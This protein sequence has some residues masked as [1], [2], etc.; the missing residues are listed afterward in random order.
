MLFFNKKLSICLLIIWFVI[1][2]AISPFVHAHIGKDNPAS[3]GSGLH[4]HEI[5]VFAFEKSQHH[6]N[7]NDYAFDTH[8]VVIDKGVVQK[9]QLLSFLFASIVI[10]NFALGQRTTQKLNPQQQI[11]PKPIVQRTKLN[12]RAP[13]YF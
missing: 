8:I 1:L 3:Q 10:F 11:Q 12:P 9:L 5:N 7:N 6:L 4:I 13:P 2:Q